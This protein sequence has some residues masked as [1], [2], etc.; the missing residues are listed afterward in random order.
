MAN[1]FN[2][3]PEYQPWVSS[4]IP[5]PLD[6]IMKAGAMKQE[7]YDSTK[8]ALQK[9]LLESKINSIEEHDPWRVNYIKNF[10]D[11]VQKLVNS[12][13]DFGSYEGKNATQ[14]LISKYSQDPN[15]EVL[16]RSIE[17]KKQTMEDWAAIQKEGKGA[18]WNDPTLKDRQLETLGINPYIDEKGNPLNYDRKITYAYSDHNKPI[19]DLFDKMKDSTMGKSGAWSHFTADKTAIESGKHIVDGIDAE[20]VIAVA[21]ANVHNYMSSDG[22]Q[23][24]LRKFEFDHK[25]ELLQMTPEEREKAEVN[26]A[27]DRMYTVGMAYVHNKLTEDSDIKATSLLDKQYEAEH[28]EVNQTTEDE[29]RDF[30]TSMSNDPEGKQFIKTNASGIKEIDWEGLKDAKNYGLK[31][32]FWGKVGDY[33][34]SVWGLVWGAVGG[35]ENFFK[36]G[37]KI[38][39]TVKANQEAGKHT[40]DNINYSVKHSYETLKNNGALPVEED[41]KTKQLK[42]IPF[43]TKHFTQILT[44][45]AQFAK[46]RGLA[47]LYTNNET[48]KKLTD[49]LNNYRDTYTYIPQGETTPIQLGD[50]RGDDV[51]K[52]YNAKDGTGAILTPVK[53]QSMP[54]VGS[55]GKI[56]PGQYES[57][58]LVKDQKGKYFY[59]RPNSLEEKTYYD[60]VQNVLSNSLNYAN[61]LKVNDDIVRNGMVDKYQFQSLVKNEDNALENYKV[62]AITPSTT[63]GQL[64]VTYQSKTGNSQVVSERKYDPYT[65][66]L[67]PVVT[68]YDSQNN[69]VY[70]PAM[71][72]NTYV[73]QTDAS[74]INGQYNHRVGK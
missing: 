11:D 10:N 69:P 19:Y 52:P 22:G 29:D 9:S 14:N 30:L 39:K 48:G 62:V 45:A 38:Q 53:R 33:M 65:N 64:T 57:V 15:L 49:K 51:L 2:T 44:A 4:Y 58:V 34:S 8:L 67:I 23:D 50:D 21:D 68:G 40:W 61:T 41:P 12:D 27:R 7:E 71:P 47:V 66:K 43:D 20:K 36:A 59:A 16:K 3:L 26:A 73:S 55:D 54:K 72:L 24:F 5:L 28:P 32:T 18:Y 13:I 56:I 17:N 60:G 37:D 63:P 35:E 31:P 1:R 46:G 6:T 42:E 74:W 70:G 25:A